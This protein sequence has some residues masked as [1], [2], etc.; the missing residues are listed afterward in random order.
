MAREVDIVTGLVGIII[1]GLG[2]CIFDGGLV[3]GPGGLDSSG[4]NL[5]APKEET[6]RCG[7]ESES[8]SSILQM[9][10]WASRTSSSFSFSFSNSAISFCKRD[11]SSSSSSVSYKDKIKINSSPTKASSSRM[12]PLCNVHSRFVT[13]LSVLGD[14]CD[15]LPPPVCSSPFLICVSPA[16]LQITLTR[17]GS[18]RT[19][20]FINTQG[21]CRESNTACNRRITTT[22]CAQ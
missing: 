13:C 15:T 10:R 11:F 1:F 19:R 16:L 22:M 3:E 14:D 18:Q 21:T 2:L 6:D 7:S 17:K 12:N 8:E 4:S 5:M 9:G 20:L